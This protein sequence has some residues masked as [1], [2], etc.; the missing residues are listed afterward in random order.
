MSQSAASFISTSQLERWC[1]TGLLTTLLFYSY[2]SLSSVSTGRSCLDLSVIF[3][4][5]IELELNFCMILVAS[6]FSFYSL[7]W[8]FLSSLSVK[9]SCLLTRLSISR[10]DW[11]AP[12]PCGK[13]CSPRFLTKLMSMGQSIVFKDTIFSRKCYW[14]WM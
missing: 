9:L 10:L 14:L 8:V 12:Y 11:Y 4:T 13:S 5:R 2:S 3:N 1:C 7:A 6:I